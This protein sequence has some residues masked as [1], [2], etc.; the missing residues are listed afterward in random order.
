MGDSRKR[1]IVSLVIL[2]W[3]FSTKL[4]KVQLGRGGYHNQAPFWSS[5]KTSFSPGQIS[6]SFL[7]CLSPNFF[8]NPLFFL[9]SPYLYSSFSGIIMPQTQ[10]GTKHEKY[11]SKVL[12]N[13]FPFWQFN[14]IKSYQVLTL[15]IIIIIP[16]KILPK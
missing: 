6:L 5:S 7:S 14:P 2:R 10:K 11:I 16:L 4:P 13:F 9:L 1:L 3:C 15:R 12:V 8:S